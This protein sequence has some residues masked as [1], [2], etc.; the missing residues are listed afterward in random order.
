MSFKQLDYERADLRARLAALILEVKL[1]RCA[2][3][4]RRDASYWSRKDSDNDSE[5]P[6]D[7]DGPSHGEGFF[8]VTQYFPKDH[9]GPPEKIN[10]AEP[11]PDENPV[12]E[13]K[14]T[15]PGMLSQALRGASAAVAAWATIAYLGQNAV[16]YWVCPGILAN[17]DPPKTFEELTKGVGTPV[18]GYQDHHISEQTSATRDG[19]PRDMIDGKDNVV[20]IPTLKH[21]E[22]TTWYSQRNPAYG[23]LS[24]REYLSGRSWQERYDFGIDQLKKNGILLP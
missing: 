22:I 13:N 12:P 6:D 7:D 20:K 15:D 24:P 2:F 4:L 18:P 5:G 19:F 17:N 14:P 8:P 9:N 1:I 3:A 16:G 10:D 11:P 21:R 23:G